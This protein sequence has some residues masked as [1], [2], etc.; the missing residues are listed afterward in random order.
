MVSHSADAADLA[1]GGL[2]PRRG[3]DLTAAAAEADHLALLAHPGYVLVVGAPGHRPLPILR[4]QGGLHL[5]LLACLHGHIVMVQ[6]DG[7]RRVH[8]G[9]IVLLGRILHRL[10]G[11]G[12]VTAL[13]WRSRGIGVIDHR[14]PG[15]VVP[16]GKPGH[17]TGD[18][19]D[20]DH[21][22]EY[23]QPTGQPSGRPADHVV[24]AAEAACALLRTDVAP[25]GGVGLV[26]LGLVPTVG[27]FRQRWVVKAA[28][29]AAADLPFS[30]QFWSAPF[31]PRHSLLYLSLSLGTC[32]R[33][34]VLY[35]IVF[36]PSSQWIS[37]LCWGIYPRPLTLAPLSL[38]IK[39]DAQDA[40]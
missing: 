3:G 33:Y 31:S 37:P 25:V 40:N 9:G 18:T 17:P 35:C 15:V 8:L 30:F 20:T 11:G 12:G 5:Q 2:I 34:S 6:H 36:C 10:G 26:F 24:S 28:A 27:A 22:K 23:R 4:G 29:V 32:P 21:H 14:R 1:D 16:A 38:I 39:V 19:G 13:V 7:L